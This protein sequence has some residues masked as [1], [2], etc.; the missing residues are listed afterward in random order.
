MVLT[1]HNFE[2]GNK[3]CSVEQNALHTQRSELETD[4]KRTQEWLNRCA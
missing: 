3:L 1:G 2:L 4:D